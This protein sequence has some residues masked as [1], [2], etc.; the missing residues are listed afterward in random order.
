MSISKPINKLFSLLTAVVILAVIIFSGIYFANVVR[1]SSLVT[2]SRIVSAIILENGLSKFNIIKNQAAVKLA[3]KYAEAYAEA[4]ITF[5]NMPRQ[6]IKD[7]LP[8]VTL[9]GDDVIIQSF[10]FEGHTLIIYGDAKDYDSIDKFAA[11][12]K[13]VTGFKNVL[14]HYYTDIDN[15]NRFE[16]ECS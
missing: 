12:I 4:A 13:E 14:P 7:F 8:I 9:S 1:S 6:D 11:S 2:K 16:I 3:V 10:R 5:E 15:V